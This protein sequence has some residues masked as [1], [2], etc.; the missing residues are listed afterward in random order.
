MK[1]GR[2]FLGLLMLIGTACTDEQEASY[3]DVPAA[4][5][6]GAFDRGWLPEIV[7]DGATNIREAH[8]VDTNATWA[9][10]D[11]GADLAA[12]REKI[13]NLGGHR[14]SAAVGTGPRRTWWP[15]VMTQSN[16]EAYEFSE[17][18]GTVVTVGLDTPARRVC[19]HRRA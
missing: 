1:V 12:V 18:G 17:H 8:N 5:S 15:D 2:A 7:P 6:A 13:A 10:F 11:A 3:A 16:L 9:C 19:F 4:R 14:V